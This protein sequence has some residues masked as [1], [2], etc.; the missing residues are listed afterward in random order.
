MN[1]FITFIRVMKGCKQGLLLLQARHPGQLHTVK[2]AV[3]FIYNSSIPMQPDHSISDHDHEISV[4]VLEM[5]RRHKKTPPSA[6]KG[7]RVLPCYWF[8]CD[9]SWTW[10]LHIICLLQIITIVADNLCEIR[11]LLYACPNLPDV[12]AIWWLRHAHYKGS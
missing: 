5:Y 8:K 2:G 6:S 9:V 1:D 3:T 11:R 7:V 12:I 4:S 10:L